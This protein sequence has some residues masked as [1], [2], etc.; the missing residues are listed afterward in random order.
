MIGQIQRNKVKMLA[1]YVS[2]WHG[3]SSE[4]VVDQLARY[5][6]Q[7]KVFVQ[8]NLTPDPQ[9]GGCAKAEVPRL[10]D[11][12]RAGGLEVRGLMAV[13]DPN[14]E[15]R[16][17]FAEVRQ[18]GE[19]LGLKEFSMGMSSYYRDALAEGATIVRLGSVL[20]GPRQVPRIDLE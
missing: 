20:F 11:S 12:A 10:V 7:A 4:R 15:A 18:L 9:R 14:R 2:T 8:V 13:A 17:Q 6:P 19:A 1:P 16:A 5:A 3:L